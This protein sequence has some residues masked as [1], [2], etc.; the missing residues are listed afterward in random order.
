MPARMAGQP[1]PTP[2]DGIQWSVR[3]TA[4][5]TAISKS[6]VQRWFDIIGEQP[7]R[8]RNF[9]LSNDPF[10]I[11]KV[12]NIVGLHLNPPDHAVVSCL[13]EKSQIQ[14]LNRTQPMLPVGLGYVEGETL[15][16]MRHGTSR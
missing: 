2:P 9:K 4:K 6:T 11:E 3:S 5:E 8:Q 13:D 15:N 1:A 7:H 14:A 10:S 16:H 12:R